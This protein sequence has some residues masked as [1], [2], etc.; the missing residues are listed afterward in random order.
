MEATY[1]TRSYRIA[2]RADKTVRINDTQLDLMSLEDKIMTMCFLSDGPRSKATA[3]A[4]SQIY[5]FTKKQ[6]NFVSPRLG[7][8]VKSFCGILTNGLQWIFLHMQWVD[9]Q[10]FTEH[11]VPIC[12]LTKNGGNYGFNL[13]SVEIGRIDAAVIVCGRGNATTVSKSS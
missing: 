11:T 13:G 9:G 12:V 6:N 10:Y 5:G 3:Q 2:G 4:L 1:R 8:F 7:E